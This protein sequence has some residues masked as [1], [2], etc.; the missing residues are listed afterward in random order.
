MAFGAE[1]GSILRM[2]VGQGL[3]LAGAGIG[4]GLVVAALL[5]G[6]VSAILVGVSPRDPV[7]FVAV[8]LFFAAVAV[9]ASAVP[10]I[11]ATRVDPA[12]TLRRE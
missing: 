6:T 9:L 10:A 1:R 2:V 12:V 5:G 3:A 7:T 8:P 4:V 11:R